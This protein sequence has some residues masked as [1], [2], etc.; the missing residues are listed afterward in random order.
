MTMPGVSSRHSPDEH[1][2]VMD[3]GDA[4][5]TTLG[6]LLRH[7][8]EN[9]G[10]TLEGLVNETKIPLRHLEALE[11]DDLAVSPGGFYQRAEIRAYAQA[12][13]LDQNLALARLEVA[14]KPAE[15]SEA[16][17][18]IAKRPGPSNARTYVPIVVGIATVA[19]V[20]LVRVLSLDE[21]ALQQK[22]PTLQSGTVTRS[23]VVETPQREASVAVTQPPSPSTAAASGLQTDVVTI[24]DSRMTTPGSEVSPVTTPTG[25]A[26]ARSFSITEL[27]VTTQPAGARVTVNGIGWG[28]S[29]VTIRHLPPGDKRI[30]VSKEGYEASERIFRVAEGRRQALDIPLQ[31]P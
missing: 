11:H 16:P 27:V 29:P 2:R 8:R 21:P 14:L 26:G 13:G 3:L 5:T 4:S 7:A 6:T 9:R 12:V 25:E 22:A 20:L 24:S 1:T 19:T 30:R 10:L 18:E 28:I 15:V 31:Q 23:A 17:P